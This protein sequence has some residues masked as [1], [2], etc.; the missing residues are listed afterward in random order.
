[1]SRRIPARRAVV[2]GAAG[3]I[4]AAIVERLLAAGFAVDAWDLD[5][6]GVHG[7]H[8]VAVDVRDHASVAAA[9][10]RLDRL[11][12]LVNAAGVSGDGRPQALDPRVWER[13][14]AVNL[15]GTFYACQA[16]HGALA[17]DGGLIVNIAS[18]TGHRAGPRRAAYCSTK[19]AVLMLT[20][21][22]AT[23]WG[24][25]GIRVVALS[26]GYVD[27]GMMRRAVDA[28]RLDVDAILARTP[29]GRVARADEV[30][31]MVLALTDERF[32]LVNGS[33]IVLDGG[34]LANG[35]Y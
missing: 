20:Q 24:A 7:A 6:R 23:D 30:A 27:T 19:A 29:A 21:V 12:L 22:L 8:G 16:L 13:V 26:P 31:R 11:D 25:D 18:V 9:A 34:W 2:T 3:G 5:A 32:E 1:M 4:G 28:G 14:V 35:G 10:E 17:A 33:A 15:S